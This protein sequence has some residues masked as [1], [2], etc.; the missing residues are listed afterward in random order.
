MPLNIVVLE[1]SKKVSTK[2]LSLKHYYRRQ[3]FLAKGL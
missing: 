3:G 1:A 2:T